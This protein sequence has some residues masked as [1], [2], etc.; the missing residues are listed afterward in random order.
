MTNVI[1]KRVLSYTDTEYKLISTLKSMRRHFPD[2]GTYFRIFFHP[3]L[4]DGTT[5][6]ETCLDNLGRIREGQPFIAAFYKMHS[7]QPG[8]T[9]YFEVLEPGRT[10]RLAAQPPEGIPAELPAKVQ[11]VAPAQ[12]TGQVMTTESHLDR[13]VAFKVAGRQYHL[14]G[15]KV[16]DQ[17]RLA[18][19]DGIPPEAQQYRKWV[20][21]VNG[22]P[23]SVKWLLSLAT[24]LGVDQFDVSYANRILRRMGIET[25]SLKQPAQGKESI[26]GDANRRYR[27]LDAEVRAMHDFLDGN[28]A[29]R[30]GDERLCY[31]VYLCLTL[32][33]HEEGARLF[34]LIDPSQVQKS[35][36]EYTRRFADVCRVR[37]EG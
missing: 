24:R 25:R 8:D 32:E 34:T 27:L 6:F 37:A 9:I 23:V 29:G 26:Q 5:F 17:A 13:N 18:L 12:K 2:K 1:F 10:Y 33:L 4:P 28:A 3:P 31:W 30:P 35:L 20:A 36:Y 21:D 16:L 22:K 11:S 14:S 15:R 19:A 7:L